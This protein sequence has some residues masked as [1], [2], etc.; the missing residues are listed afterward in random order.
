[1]GFL[2]VPLL[3]PQLDNGLGSDSQILFESQCFYWSDSWTAEISLP[4]IPSEFYGVI[5]VLSF[6]STVAQSAFAVLEIE[7][8]LCHTEGR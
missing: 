3:L 2:Y 5:A 6:L 8:I 4:G 7:D 1:L